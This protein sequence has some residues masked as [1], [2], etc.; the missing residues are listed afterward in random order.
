MKKE[1]NIAIEY[2]DNG[3]IA[4]EIEEGMKVPTFL[5]KREV[6]E[7]TQGSPIMRALDR[8]ASKIIPRDELLLDDNGN[9]ILRHIKI[10]ISDEPIN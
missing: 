9:A 4:T 2:T 5:S 10:I 3:I 7:Y 6:Y 1:I 8:F